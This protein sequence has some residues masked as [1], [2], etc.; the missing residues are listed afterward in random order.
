MIA[1]K[2]GCNPNNYD[3]MYKGRLLPP[4]VTLASLNMVT[5]SILYLIK[6]PQDLVWISIYTPNCGMVSFQIKKLQTVGYA[7]A[8]V[9]SM[10]NSR[11]DEAGLLLAGKALED[12]RTLASYCIDDH[13]VLQLIYPFQVSLK[14]YKARTI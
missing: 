3:L 14:L 5:H 8:V 13:T 2:L 7:R 11:V 12:S 4:R 9:G 10:I 1:N 6:I